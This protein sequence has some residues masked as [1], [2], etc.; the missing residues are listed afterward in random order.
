[1][2]SDR[3]LYE[4]SIVSNNPLRPFLENYFQTFNDAG[5][6]WKNAKVGI[7]KVSSPVPMYKDEFMYYK[8]HDWHGL[9]YTQ[10]ENNGS[11]TA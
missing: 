2:D 5:A 3:Y 11:T 1:M 10:G 6:P 8:I 7:R 9:T 4:Y